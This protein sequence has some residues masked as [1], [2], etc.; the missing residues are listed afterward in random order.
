MNGDTSGLSRRRLLRRAPVAVAAIG[1]CVALVTAVA[2][3]TIPDG[4]DTYTA[5]VLK[6]VGTIRVIDPSVP[7]G[8][9]TGHCTSLEE[10]IGW[11]SA[12]QTGPP[13]PKGEAGGA[14]QAGRKGP[15]GELG[16]PGPKGVVGPPGARGP[17]G[18]QGQTGDAGPDGDQGPPGGFSGAYVSPNGLYKLRV[19]DTG[20]ELSGPS[21]STKLDGGGLN[22]SSFG[23]LTITAALIRLNGCSGFVALVGGQTLGGVVGVDPA[24]NPI[25]GGF[26]TILGPG[27]PT[28]CA[29]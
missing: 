11:K 1:C 7:A 13:G 15:R 17:T 29:G 14:G 28:V 8:D 24:G 16:D 27:S 19:T 5:C 21:G 12:G 18:D 26:A 6:G 4:G 3:A 2:S 20:I 23:P 22:V 9:L 25:L 10:Q